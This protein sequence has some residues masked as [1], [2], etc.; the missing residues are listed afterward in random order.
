MMTSN[1]LSSLAP[2]GR[3]HH[4]DCR[5][6]HSSHRRHARIQYTR[7][8]W[9]PSTQPVGLAPFLAPSILRRTDSSGL[10]DAFTWQIVTKHFA[11]RE[12]LP[13]LKSKEQL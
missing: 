11:R 9:T 7:L 12:T 2:V 4:F 10:T 6:D 8:T 13:A 3:I 1:F 5:A